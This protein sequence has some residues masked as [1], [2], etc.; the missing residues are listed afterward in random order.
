MTSQDTYPAVLIVAVNPLSRTSNNGKTIAS[1]FKG[2][3]KRSLAQLYFHR[4]VPTSDVCDNYYRISDEDLIRAMARGKLPAGRPMAAAR[5]RDVDAVDRVIPESVANRLRDS[6]AA[7]LLRSCLWRL[8]DLE[9]PAVLAWLDEV[10]PDVIFFCGGDANYL[11]KSVRGLARRYDAKIV[12]Y[13]T[14]DYVLPVRTLNVFQAINRAWT[15]R[16]FKAMCRDSSLI[17]TIGDKMSRTYQARF[18][19]QSQ[20][21]MNL[22]DMPDSEPVATAP[23]HDVLSFTYVGGLHSNRWRVLS[24]LANSLARISRNGVQAQL[25]VYSGQRP[26]SAVLEALDRPPYSAYCGSLDRE[27]VE[28]VLRES[29]VLVHVESGDRRSK[30]VTRLSISTKISEYM[31]SGRP[32]LAIGPHDVASIEYLSETDSAFVVTSLSPEVLDAQLQEI[33][34]DGGRR[35]ELARRAWAIARRSHDAAVVRPRLQARIIE[36]VDTRRRSF[37]AQD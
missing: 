6:W 27:G 19:I 11:Y 29:D 20:S 35:D 12:Y 14:D 18:G 30:R 23:A 2:Y 21:V 17:L 8:V 25:R 13:I 4:E 22:V 36:L 31:A 34:R 28:V 24:E 15:R 1:F 37:G 26:D 10:R 32:I 16:A 3:P 7:R 5:T 9:H 33:V